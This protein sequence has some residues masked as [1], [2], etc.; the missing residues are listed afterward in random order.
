MN[1]IV[2]RSVM[3]LLVFG[4]VALGSSLSIISSAQRSLGV[5]AA[6]PFQRVAYQPNSIG[7][8][9]AWGDCALDSNKSA[10][11][12]ALCTREIRRHYDRV[13]TAEKTRFSRIPVGII[14]MS[15]ELD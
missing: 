3:I 5:A 14:R 2:F 9:R 1:S 15:R 7:S 6:S 12:R 11:V 4:V 8:V 13:D 10:E